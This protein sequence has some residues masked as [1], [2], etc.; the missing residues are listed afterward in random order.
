MRKVEF[1]IVLP[2]TP[3]VVIMFDILHSDKDNFSTKLANATG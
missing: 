2:L 1:E 3:E